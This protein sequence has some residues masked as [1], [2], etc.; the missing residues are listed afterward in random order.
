MANGHGTDAT[1]TEQERV[2]SPLLLR[3]LVA[4]LF[5]GQANF[6]QPTAPKRNTAPVIAASGCLSQDQSRGG[7]LD[8]QKEA[9]QRGVI[10]VGTGPRRL[11][12]RGG[13]VPSPN[14]AAQAGALDPVRVAV[15]SMPGATTNSRTGSAATPEFRLGRVQAV[16][17]SC[18]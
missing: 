18:P 17:G 10:V 12:I 1:K 3:M 8:R 6:T 2:M 13:L 15:A 4:T 11:T 14:V 7:E 9:G 5:A 16:S